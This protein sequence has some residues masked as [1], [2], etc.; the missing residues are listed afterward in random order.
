MQECVVG[1]QAVLSVSASVH[2]VCCDLY[3]FS[4]LSSQISALVSTEETARMIP[5]SLA[6]LNANAQ[7]ASLVS[8]VN[9]LSVSVT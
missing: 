8:S 4:I 7:M 2:Y 3:L 6:S 5:S 1:I 9:R